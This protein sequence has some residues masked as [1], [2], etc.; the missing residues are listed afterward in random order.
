VAL[1]RIV[2][3]AG[4]SLDLII[5]DVMMVEIHLDVSKQNIAKVRVKV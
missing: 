1:L 4:A 5:S 2:F 3:N